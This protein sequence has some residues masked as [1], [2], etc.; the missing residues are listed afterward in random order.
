[1]KSYKDISMKYVLLR[2][3]KNYE[4]R[5]SNFPEFIRFIFRQ[6]HTKSRQQ[7]FLLRA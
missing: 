6:N 7:T 4:D 2:L 5:E 1:M 3:I